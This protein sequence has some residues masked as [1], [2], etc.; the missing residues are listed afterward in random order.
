MNRLESQVVHNRPN[1]GGKLGE[2]AR[3]A[4]TLGKMNKDK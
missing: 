3:L 4:Q 1:K 2:R